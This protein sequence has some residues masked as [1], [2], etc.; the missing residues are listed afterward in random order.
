MRISGNSCTLPLKVD[1]LPVSAFGL[2]G[3]HLWLVVVVCRHGEVA[4]A[5]VEWAR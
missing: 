1:M 5:K 4:G 3:W 2:F